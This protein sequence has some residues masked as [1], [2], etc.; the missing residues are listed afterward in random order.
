MTNLQKW[1]LISA[2]WIIAISLLLGGLSR[3]SYISNIP[4]TFDKWTGT[5]ILHKI[6][7]YIPKPIKKPFGQSDFIKKYGQPDSN[8]SQ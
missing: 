8:P 5:I 7:D 2:I 3:Y 1:L 6:K 4:A